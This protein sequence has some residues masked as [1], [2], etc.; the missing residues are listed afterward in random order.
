MPP[1]RPLG[2]PDPNPF[3]V[4]PVHK[5]GKPRP[6]RREDLPK[7]DKYEPGQPEPDPGRYAPPKPKDPKDVIDRMRPRIANSMASWRGIV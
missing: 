2:P 7:P 3:W 6:H 5:P 4:P 1:I